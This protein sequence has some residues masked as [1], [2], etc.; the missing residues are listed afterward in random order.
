MTRVNRSSGY[1]TTN[2]LKLWYKTMGRGCAYC[3]N[4]M[5]TLEDALKTNVAQSQSSIPFPQDA[6]TVEHV[7]AKG[8]GGS[9]ALKNKVICCFRCNSQKDDLAIDP[10]TLI[11]DE[12]KK[13]WFA[14][15]DQWI[16]ATTGPDHLQPDP[17]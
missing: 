10:A 7:I 9:N 11:S 2:L 6:P 15:I 12:A 14:A 4:K 8:N 17:Y 16:L 3:G 5:L 1:R 13:K